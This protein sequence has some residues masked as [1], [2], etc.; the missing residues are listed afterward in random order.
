MQFPFTSWRETALKLQIK[1]SVFGDDSDTLIAR[2]A[3]P[4]SE[5]AMHKDRKTQG[6]KKTVF[7]ESW[8]LLK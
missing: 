8:L 4:D 5:K 2:L 7:A 1:R 3:R 6:S